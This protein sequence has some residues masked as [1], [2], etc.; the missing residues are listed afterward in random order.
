MVAKRELSSV[1]D[2]ELDTGQP[3]V[4]AVGDEARRWYVGTATDKRIARLPK[5]LLKVRHQFMLQHFSVRYR[6]NEEVA[7]TWDSCCDSWSQDDQRVTRR[8]AGGSPA[9][10]A[11]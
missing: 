1:N 6:C 2:D 11:R 10:D 3:N 4:S 9:L 5:V 7:T 8:A